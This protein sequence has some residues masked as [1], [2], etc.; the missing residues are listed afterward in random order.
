M[1]IFRKNFSVFILVFLIVTSLS[2][3]SSLELFNFN[4]FISPKISSSP[5][6]AVVFDE[7][8][9]DLNQDIVLKVASFECTP[10]VVRSD[11]LEEQ[12]VIVYCPVQAMQLNPLMKI[13]S[14]DSISF[15]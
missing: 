9:C 5:Q 14:I 1:V 6:D 2:L 12:D 11:L 4:N 8:L 10:S 7:S 13:E 3:V 15:T